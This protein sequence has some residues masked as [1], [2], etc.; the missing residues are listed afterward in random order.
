M[1]LDHR[2]GFVKGFALLEYQSYDESKQAIDNLNGI[3][4]LGSTISC[5]YAFVKKP[6]KK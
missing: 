2:T 5:D 3:K 4:I 1:D 6:Q